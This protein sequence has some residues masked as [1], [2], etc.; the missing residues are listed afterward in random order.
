MS[1]GEAGEARRRRRYGKWWTQFGWETRTERDASVEKQPR[2]AEGILRLRPELH[3]LLKAV[4]H[5][6]CKRNTGGLRVT[7]TVAAGTP[8]R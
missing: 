5:A 3:L 2:E 4:L 6:A 8:A 7:G 1:R